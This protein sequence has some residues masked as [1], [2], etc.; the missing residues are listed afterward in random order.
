MT[1][2]L[3]P[4][5]AGSVVTVGAFDGLHLGHQ[6]VLAETVRRA[7]A[8]GRAAVLVT[9][10]PHPA[11]VLRPATAPPRLTLP[12]E[13]RE[14]LAELGLDYVM[15][16]RFDQALAARSAEAFVREVLLDRCRCRELVV[17]WDHHFGRDREGGIELLRRLGGAAGFSVDVVPPVEA[18]GERVSS[19]RLRRLVAQGSLEEAARC[20]GRPYAVSGVVRHGAGRGR[21]LGVPTANLAVP[22]RKQLPPDGVYAVRVE[23]AGGVAGG[24]LNQGHRPT[25]D[26]GRRWLEAH[27]FGFDGVLYG[28]PVRITWAAWLREVQRFASVE[29]LREQLERDREA[30]LAALRRT[31]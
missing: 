10:E 28:Q 7:R 12:R 16:L 1:P 14:V 18:D 26:D 25:F 9:F 13:R 8:S 27:L 31:G 30:A 2:G 21:Q 11:E 24:M 20:L 22:A 19:T 23:W 3:P 6:Q 5:P 29:A 17:G 4:L 15:V